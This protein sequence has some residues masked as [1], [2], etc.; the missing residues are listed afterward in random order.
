LSQLFKEHNSS[1]IRRQLS[2]QPKSP[3]AR[4]IGIPLGKRHHP[5]LQPRPRQDIRSERR[6]G[7]G[8]CVVRSRRCLWE[9]NCG[10]ELQ[11]RSSIVTPS[12]FLARR[13]LSLPAFTSS[14]SPFPPQ[15]NRPNSNHAQAFRVG[16]HF[17]HIQGPGLSPSHSNIYGNSPLQK[18]AVPIVV[19]GN[20]LAAIRSDGS[21]AGLELQ[22]ACRAGRLAMLQST[23]ASIIMLRY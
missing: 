9:M 18:P 15:R 11:V 23:I 13:E 21:V 1:F 10:R 5:P 22:Q 14:L 20:L 8:E 3:V 17:A 4:C 12:R 19:R 6:S 2:P 7:H 16:R